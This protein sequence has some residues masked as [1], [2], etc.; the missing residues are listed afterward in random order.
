[1][2][3]AEFVKEMV[4]RDDAWF[5]GNCQIGKGRRNAHQD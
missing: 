3:K 4:L 5:A 2:K 1:V